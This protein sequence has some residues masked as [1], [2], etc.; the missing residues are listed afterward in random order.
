MANSLLALR[1]KNEIN[2]SLTDVW[3]FQFMCIHIDTFGLEALIAY[4]KLWCKPSSSSILELEA[5][6]KQ[7][8]NKHWKYVKFHSLPKVLYLFGVEFF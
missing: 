4:A 7:S 8:K 3:F 5:L 6:Y 2:P 1:P